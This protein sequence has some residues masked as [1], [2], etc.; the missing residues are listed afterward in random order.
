[1]K[2]NIV[3]LSAMFMVCSIL[4]ICPPSQSGVR[5][6]IIDLDKQIL[7]VEYHIDIEAS[8]YQTKK[9]FTFPADGFSFAD[10]S[11]KVT[12]VRDFIT[13]ED[14]RWSLVPATN[15][16]NSQ[17]LQIS[18]DPPSKREIVKKF[19]VDIAVEA[20][21][22]NIVIGDKYNADNVT[23]KYETSR[24]AS[25]VI[26]GGYRLIGSSDYVL[27]GE[28]DYGVYVSVKGRERNHLSF[29]IRECR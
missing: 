13:G 20:H 2:L 17:M 15:D 6:R 11:I 4:A 8:A 25:F 3:Y 10:D 27:F 7:E 19:T 28:D 29:T 18:Y 12:H 22:K 26:P 5:L 1:M 24:D 23:V 16:P 14:L 21:T 9:Y